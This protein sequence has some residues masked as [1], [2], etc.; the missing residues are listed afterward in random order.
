MTTDDDQRLLVTRHEVVDQV[1]S[2]LS[3]LV[4]D[5]H[6]LARSHSFHGEALEHYEQA[7]SEAGKPSLL[8][9]RLAQSDVLKVDESP[10][11][12]LPE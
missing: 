3:D 1:L 10:F 4:L 7:R 11:A 2:V 9:F 6:A 12:V 8:R 5:R